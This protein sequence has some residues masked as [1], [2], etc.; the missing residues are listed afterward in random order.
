MDD[1]NIFERRLVS[2]IFSMQLVTFI[3]KEFNIELSNDDLDI[4]NFKDVNSI[5]ALVESKM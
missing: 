1:D 4:D 3:E 5:V 2:S